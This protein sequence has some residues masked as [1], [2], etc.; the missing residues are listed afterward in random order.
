VRFDDDDK[1]KFSFHPQWK[2]LFYL[3]DLAVIVALFFAGAWAFRSIVGE[4]KL[5]E[6]VRL[7]ELAKTKGSRALVQAD[8]VLAAENGRLQVAVTDSATTADE[9]IRRRAALDATVAEQQR[10]NQALYPL[11]DQVF[12]LQYRATTAL[13]EVRQ[14]KEDLRTRRGELA[15]LRAKAADAARQLAEAQDRHEDARSQLAQA[16]TMRAYEPAGVFPD[17][18]G[19]VVRQ[20]ISDTQDLTNVEFQQS[21]WAP[22]RQIDLGVSLGLG[23]G[24]GEVASSK[25][26]GLLLTRSLIHRRLGLDFGAGYSVLTDPGGTDDAGAYA[27]AGLRFSPFYK[28]RFHLGLGARASGDEVTPFLSIGLGRR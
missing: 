26:V 8:S 15:S 13:S 20:D 23:L 24:S 6:G 5:A 16:R 4:K 14:Y 19:L 12:D 28:E 27:S 18:S 10:V 7:R 22:A 9:L 11:T 3:V 2:H 21:L 1:P 17:K 25:N